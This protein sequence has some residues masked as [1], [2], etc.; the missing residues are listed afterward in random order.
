MIIRELRLE[1]GWSQ[2]QL[3][4]L[5]GVS[6]RTIQRIENDRNAGLETWKSLAAAFDVPVKALMPNIEEHPERARAKE[7]VRAIRGFLTHLI[8]YVLVIGFL[9][10]VN[11]MTDKQNL[12]ALWAA[13]GWGIFLGI[14]ALHV[15]EEHI[16]GLA[17]EERQVE[18][19]MQRRQ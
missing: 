8:G 9:V 3:A 19:R 1:R 11:L 4:Q 2:E 10:F 14:H 16:F 13:M 7:D 17:W 15:F 18:K 6:V 12:W 5:S